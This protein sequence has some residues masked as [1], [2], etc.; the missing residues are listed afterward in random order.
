MDKKN[1][2]KSAKK[3]YKIKNRSNKQKAFKNHEI[4][5]PSKN[6]KKR[7]KSN[8]KKPDISKNLSNQMKKSISNRKELFENQL[9]PQSKSKSKVFGFR[10]KQK[11]VTF[12]DKNMMKMQH[13]NFPGNELSSQL[14]NKYSQKVSNIS[15]SGTFLNNS[16]LMSKINKSFLKSDFIDSFTPKRVI[17]NKLHE[18]SFY[19]NYVSNRTDDVPSSLEP[20][21]QNITIIAPSEMARENTLKNGSLEY[22]KKIK[23]TQIMDLNDHEINEKI[24]ELNNP[25]N[26][27]EAI[28]IGSSPNKTSKNISETSQSKIIIDSSLQS[29]VQSDPADK[30]QEDILI[31]HKSQVVN[32]NFSI[33]RPISKSNQVVIQ[34]SRDDKRAFSASQRESKSKSSKVSKTSRLSIESKKSIQSESSEKKKPVLPDFYWKFYSKQELAHINY[35]KGTP[36]VFYLYTLSNDFFNVI[37]YFH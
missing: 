6:K 11:A 24:N 23:L 12:L 37:R 10:K 5:L 20:E 31:S 15:Q 27:S 32:R 18:S 22:D 3:K 9:E 30:S 8:M 2:R 19:Q 7:S 21:E 36:S 33:D 34:A 28:E 29:V 16:I 17:N 35:I 25:E 4:V 14:F 26:Q 13:P 1:R